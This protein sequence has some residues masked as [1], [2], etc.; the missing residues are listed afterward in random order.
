MGAKYSKKMEGAGAG[1]TK[2]TPQYLAV[3]E[4]QNFTGVPQ[5]LARQISVVYVVLQKCF[6][7][8]ISGDDDPVA[9]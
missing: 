9:V 5:L 6:I 2:H 7:F 8:G 1:E 4:L 3:K